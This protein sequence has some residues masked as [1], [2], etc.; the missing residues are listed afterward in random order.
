[1][2]Q[3]SNIPGLSI[4]TAELADALDIVRLL[5]A[6][7]T[8]LC[9]DDHKGRKERLRAW[10]ENKTVANVEAWIQSAANCM[11]V[12]MQDGDMAGV[13][14]LRADGWLTLNY[15]APANRF[16]GVSKLLLTV[17]ERRAAEFGLCSLRLES[18]KTALSFYRTAGFIDAGPI[19]IKHGMSIYPLEKRLIADHVDAVLREG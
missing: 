6:S 11:V 10:L 3:K 18:T 4:R 9:V 15:V 8:E 12:A 2:F 17:I 16:H 1:M 7:I 19:T 5:R 14:C 13:G